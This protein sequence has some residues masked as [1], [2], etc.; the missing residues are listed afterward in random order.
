VSQ[1]ITAAARSWMNIPSPRFSTAGN[2][3]LEARKADKSEDLAQAME[4]NHGLDAAAPFGMTPGVVRQPASMKVLI[5]GHVV[6]EA[7]RRRKQGVEL[8]LLDRLFI[9]LAALGRADGLENF[10]VRVWRKFFGDLRETLEHGK[11]LHR[12]HRLQQIPDFLYGSFNPA[13]PVRQR[14]HA[15]DLREVRIGGRADQ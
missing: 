14:Q 11:R 3:G 13:S 7:L 5:H 4:L 15:D 8:D 9:S 1:V 10:V 2:H 6:A 12:I